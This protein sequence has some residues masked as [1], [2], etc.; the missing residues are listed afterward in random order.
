MFQIFS[1]TC[2]VPQFPIFWSLLAHY[3]VHLIVLEHDGH[4]HKMAD[5]LY[6]VA[7]GL[8]LGQAQ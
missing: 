8:E 7:A 5:A 1:S 3:G 4:F 6:T 2:P